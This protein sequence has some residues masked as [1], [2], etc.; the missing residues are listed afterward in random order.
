MASLLWTRL[1]VLPRPWRL[2]HRAIFLLGP[3]GARAQ[4]RTVLRLP[5]PHLETAAPGPRTILWPQRGLVSCAHSH[6]VVGV[7]RQLDL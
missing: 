4:T 5:A 2:W 6:H 3:S 7:P 1:P